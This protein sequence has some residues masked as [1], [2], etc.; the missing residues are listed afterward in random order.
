MPRAK[1]NRSH[2]W[3]VEGKPWIYRRPFLARGKWRVRRR[4][5]L[6]EGRLEMI[7]LASK[8][9]TDAKR[10]VEEMAR[11]ERKAAEEAEANGGPIEP[12]NATVREALDEWLAVMRA[13]SEL[14]ERS[15]V[16]YEKTIP[17]YARMLTPDR[18]VASLEYGDV[19]RLFTE[20]WD[21]PETPRGHKSRL[22]WKNAS[23]RTRIM[24]RGALVRWL[25]WCRKKGYTRANPAEAFEIPASW[26]KEATRATRETGQALSP[27]E[28]RR[29]LRA[30]EDPYLVDFTPRTRSGK[31]LAP[32]STTPSEVRPPGWLHPFVFLSLRT[33]L[34]VSNLLGSPHKPPLRWSNL[35][36]EKG[37]VRIRAEHMK[38]DSMF[39]APLHREVVEYLRRLRGDRIPAPEDAVIPGMTREVDRPFHAV[40]RR[41]GLEEPVTGNFLGELRDQDN[42]H[43]FRVHD[44]RHSALSLMGASLPEFVVA[45]LAGHAGGS[46]T[47]KYAGKIPIDEL[48]RHLDA[49]PPLLEEPGGDEHPSKRLACQTG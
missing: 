33:G 14:R 20:Q 3:S 40:L 45:R 6:V 11:K 5:R 41:A 4:S 7:T 29:F 12:K 8:N 48:R 49:L 39:G 13:K 1:R 47:R 42:P 18:L 36:L 38:N 10:D 23:G 31:R 22:G 17:L 43:A 46:I 19:E 28:M 16:N 37:V 30:C 32:A 21:D 24:H 34:R 27:D 26:Q 9:L 35:D 25:A 44:L 2:M 15:A